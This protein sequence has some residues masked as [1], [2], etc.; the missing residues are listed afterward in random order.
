MKIDIKALAITLAAGW[1]GMILLVGLI[2]LFYPAYGREFLDIL[3]S[4]YPGYKGTSTFG[5]VITATLYGLVDVFIG[6]LILGWLY[7]RLAK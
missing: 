2:N 3:V 7:N 5:S 1:G 6:A 4:I